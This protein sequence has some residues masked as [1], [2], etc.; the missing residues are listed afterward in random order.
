MRH[1]ILSA[2]EANRSDGLRCVRIDETFPVREQQVIL[3]RVQRRWAWVGFFLLVINSPFVALV[4]H[5]DS[6]LL[7]V[8][9]AAIVAFLIIIDDAQ[10]RRVPA[11][12]APESE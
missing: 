4:I 8:T 9:V 3:S 6:W 1:I 5:D 11:D 12:N 2:G 10:R 7:S